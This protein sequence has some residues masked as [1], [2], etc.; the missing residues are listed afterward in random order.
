MLIQRFV[1]F[2]LQHLSAGYVA[3][4]SL[5]NKRFGVF[6]SRNYIANTLCVRRA[7]LL[8]EAFGLYVRRG[9]VGA[10][11]GK[12]WRSH[13]ALGQSFPKVGASALRRRPLRARKV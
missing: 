13:H 5:P 3:V 6:M 7:G 12:N 8:H 11:V 2:Q 1:E 10:R 9:R 4:P